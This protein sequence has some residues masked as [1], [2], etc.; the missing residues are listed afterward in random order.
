MECITET[1]TCVYTW[2]R[3][4]GIS[5]EEERNFKTLPLND[6][7][8]KLIEECSWAGCGLDFYEKRPILK[9]ARINNKYYAFCCE[10]CYHTWLKSNYFFY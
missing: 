10:E 8:F 9:K 1:L 3:K 6:E 5:L 7:N 2:T 4:G